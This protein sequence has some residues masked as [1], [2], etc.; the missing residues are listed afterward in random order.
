MGH[1]VGKPLDVLPRY[2]KQPV[3]LGVEVH[4]YVPGTVTNSEVS[5]SLGCSYLTS[6]IQSLIA[7]GNYPFPTK[8]EK[9]NSSS[10]I[11]SESSLCYTLAAHLE[12]PSSSA[13][14]TIIRRSHISEKRKSFLLV[15]SI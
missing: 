4:S 8:L 6:K 3:L 14:T 15:L 11:F 13:V 2:G 9:K 12:L 7:Q 5:T 10:F 1:A